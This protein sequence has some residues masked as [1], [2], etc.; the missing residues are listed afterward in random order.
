MS[1]KT[2]DGD[3]LSNKFSLFQA[4][5]QRLLASLIG[6]KTEAELSSEKEREEKEDADYKDESL[7]YE[8]Y[9]L[10]YKCFFLEPT[11]YL[12]GLALELRYPRRSRTEASHGGMCPQTTNYWRS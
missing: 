8:R 9:V 1:K 7:G 12:L 11:K 2:S 10:R 5:Q 4:N 3:V 6:P